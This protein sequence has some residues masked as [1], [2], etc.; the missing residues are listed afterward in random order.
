M[1]WWIDMEISLV[2]AFGWSLQDIEESD[3]ESLIPF[4]LRFTETGGRSE[5]KR[6]SVNFVDVA[7]LFR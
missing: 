4:V 7:H 5:P 6:Q 1:T 2:K 3:M